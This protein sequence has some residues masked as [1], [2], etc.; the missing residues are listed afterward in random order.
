M[1]DKNRIVIAL[2]FILFLASC[3]GGYCS[4]EESALFWPPP[5]AEMR[6]SFIKSVYSPQDTGLK[7]GLFKKLKGMI[8]GEEK[9]ILNKPIAVAVDSQKTIFICDPGRPALHIFKQKERQYKRITEINDEELISPV[10][11]A[12]TDNGLIFVSDSNLK[13]VFCLDRNGKFKFSVG[14]DKKFLRPTGVTVSKDR[15]YIVD[16]AA[17]NVLIFDL[18]G[19][20]I[21]EFGKRGKGASE[22]NYPASIAADK[23]G[24]IYVVDALNFR[25]QVFGA[26]NKFLYSIGKAGNSSGSFSRPKGVAVDS[27]GHIYTTDGMFDNLQIFNQEKEF[28]L[29]LGESGQKDGEFWIPSG[30]AIDKDNYIYVAD[31]YNKRIQI[32]RY[33]GKE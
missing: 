5:P 14:Q 33:V 24:K 13:K 20:F 17:H 6:I 29:S 28:L 31:S 4:E 10:G 8:V 9:D 21:G 22:F 15:L 2:F 11:V 25:I 3:A 27:F 19:N 1:A 26:D 30:I 16:T 23:E 18:K 12:A 32:F 7:A